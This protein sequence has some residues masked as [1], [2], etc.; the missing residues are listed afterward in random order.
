MARV[1]TP[2]ARY[3]SGETRTLRLVGVVA[4]DRVGVEENVG[5][6]VEIGAV[7]TKQDQDGFQLEVLLH[8]VRLQ[9]RFIGVEVE[10]GVVN[11]ALPMVGPHGDRGR[12]C[13]R[14]HG[15]SRGAGRGYEPIIAYA[16]GAAVGTRR[17]ISRLSPCSR[18]GERAC[19]PS[20]PSSR[21]PRGSGLPMHRARRQRPLVGGVEAVEGRQ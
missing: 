10:A 13:R 20:R 15:G 16:P 11:L 8:G 7:G 6:A 2:K 21:L 4:N 18:L 12:R 19:L 3:T 5:P 14:G 9:D 17:A 1:S